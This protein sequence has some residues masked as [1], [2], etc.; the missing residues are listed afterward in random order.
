MKEASVLRRIHQ[1]EDGLKII[2][3][4]IA[5]YPDDYDLVN[6]KA[7]WLQYLNSKEEAL[8]VPAPA[9]IHE[10]NQKYVNV[11]DPEKA[12]KVIRKQV[13]LGLTQ[14]RR[15]EIVSGLEL[16]ETILMPVRKFGRSGKRGQKN[17]FMP[18]RSK[19]RRKPIAGGGPGR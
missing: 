3:D 10:D 13:E 4:L 5:N 2:N 17:P 1:V 7:Y 18:D 14:G 19:F 6:Y 16:G 11:P 12:D 8:F 9:I 15:V